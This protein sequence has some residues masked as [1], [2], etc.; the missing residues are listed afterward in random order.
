MR[1]IIR[2]KEVTDLVS[3][4][5]DYELEPVKVLKYV[6][7]IIIDTDNDE[8]VKNMR[9]DDR[10]KAV[11]SNDYQTTMEH[12]LPP[13][14][15]D[16]LVLSPDKQE[17]Y[18]TRTSTY[19]GTSYEYGPTYYGRLELL[20]SIDYDK[21]K[22]YHKYEP[23][24]TGDGVDIYIIDGGINFENCASAKKAGVDILVSGTAVFK[25]NEGNVKKNI[26]ILKNH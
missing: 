16:S 5:D 4:V 18:G 21:N 23:T 15:K 7:M 2:V 13:E 10:V 6:M 20:S 3:V 22:D 24:K 8:L 25:N 26:E 9:V 11:T 1:Y 19:I 14:V 17:D 12:P